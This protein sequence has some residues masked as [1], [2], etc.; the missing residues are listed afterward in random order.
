MITPIQNLEGP[1]LSNM[2]KAERPCHFCGAPVLT[3]EAI[4]LVACK[5]EACQVAMAALDRSTKAAEAKSRLEETVTRAL[6]RCGMGPAELGATRQGCTRELLALCAPHIQD[7][8]GRPEN[9]LG[10]FGL[11]GGNG[12]GKTGLIAWLTREW[13]WRS[14]QACLAAYGVLDLRCWKPVWAN[15]ESKLA[16]LHGAF[17]DGWRL[18]DLMDEMKDAPLLVLEDLGAEQG[19]ADRDASWSN[20]QLYEILEARFSANRA[21]LWTTNCKVAELVGRYSPRIYSRLNGLAPLIEAPTGLPDRRM[22][23]SRGRVAAL[24]KSRP[25]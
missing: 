11:Y 12:I 23:A 3:Y 25:A 17:G 6:R 1:R 2:L 14:A 8:L 13:T 4:P 20:Q 24:A 5:A 22:L 16:E 7:L 21:T 15:W 19:K 9:P 10:G 18:A